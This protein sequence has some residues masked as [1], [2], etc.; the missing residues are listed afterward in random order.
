MQK[1]KNMQYIEYTMQSSID[2]LH[3]ICATLATLLSRNPLLLHHWE[4]WSHAPRPVRQSVPRAASSTPLRESA[5]RPRSTLDLEHV[6][7]SFAPQHLRLELYKS[8]G[9]PVARTRRGTVEEEAPTA[10]TTLGLLSHKLVAHM[11]EDKSK[12]DLMKSNSILS[13][14]LVVY[15]IHL[16]VF[17]IY[18]PWNIWG[19]P[20]LR[21]VEII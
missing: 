6:N 14:S 21:H 18:N 20:M 2:I 1:Y 5:S 3:I 16:C 10:G 12:M 15:I 13:L 7:F 9:Q 8:A 17:V 11:T 4:H 19:L